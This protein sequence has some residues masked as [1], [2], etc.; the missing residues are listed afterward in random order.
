MTEKEIIKKLEAI[1]KQVND[2]MKELNGKSQDNPLNNSFSKAIN[3]ETTDEQ[4]V[5]ALKVLKNLPF[6]LSPKQFA[7]VV[8]TS[9]YHSAVGEDIISFIRKQFSKVNDPEEFVEDVA[10]ILR[11]HYTTENNG[12]FIQSLISSLKEISQED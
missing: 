2:L 4:Y 9:R 1:Q 7:Y 6:K 5:D 12:D 10:V 3:K 11:K 8:S